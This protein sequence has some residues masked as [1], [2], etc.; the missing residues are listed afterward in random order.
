MWGS[1]QPHSTALRGGG[2][3]GRWPRCCT[4]TPHPT[5]GIGHTALIPPAVAKSFG[6]RPY[7]PESVVGVPP[8]APKPPSVGINPLSLCGADQRSRLRGRLRAVG[9]GGGR[10]TSS[11]SAGVRPPLWVPPGPELSTRG[12][13]SRAERSGAESCAALSHALRCRRAAVGARCAMGTALWAPRLRDA[14]RGAHTASIGGE[15]E[16]EG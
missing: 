12:E 7:C 5:L 3:G 1:P 16:R 13:R 6:K 2:Q 11:P 8:A 4:L 9:G 10:A 15:G 14:R